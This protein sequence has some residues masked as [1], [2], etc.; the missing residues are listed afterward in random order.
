MRLL[1]SAVA[2]IA[3]AA[4]ASGVWPNAAVAQIIPESAKAEATTGNP[5]LAPLKW[6]GML[7][8]PT[9]TKDDPTSIEEC[10]AQFITVSVLLTAAHCVK[11]IINNPTGPWADVTKGT[12]WLQYQ[13]QEGT[14]YKILCAAANPLW[15]L[16]A[17]YASMKNSDKNDAQRNAF[18][19]DFAMILVDGSS[20]T[21]VMPY[22]LDWKGKVSYVT[23]VGYAGDILDGQIIQKSGGALFFADSVPMLPRNYPNI[24]VQ[25]APITDLTEGTSGGAWIANFS[26][27]EGDNNNIL[28]AVPRSSSPTIPAARARPI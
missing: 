14:P 19:H 18:E 2:L 25:W 20:T 16:P 10:T 1:R 15:K 8:V 27:A 22:A 4:G 17:N 28:V 11:D 12:F 7:V 5:S 3:L 24:V 6:V 23:R 21:G 13:N 26:T 9:P